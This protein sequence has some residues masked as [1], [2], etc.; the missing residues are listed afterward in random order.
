MKPKTFYY[1]LSI[2]G[3][4][5]TVVL[6]LNLGISVDKLILTLIMY[7]LFSGLFLILTLA[8]L[9]IKLPFVTD[10]IDEP[11]DP[12]YRISNEFTFSDWRLVK[13]EVGY[14]HYNDAI[15][16]LFPPLILLKYKTMVDLEE[17]FEFE[18]KPLNF[19]GSLKDEYEKM[20]QIKYKCDI[21]YNELK[22]RRDEAVSIINQEYE[23]NF[24][25]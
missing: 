16:F 17:S 6:I 20:Y 1:S 25:K 4:L 5:S 22:Q 18:H 8:G 7:T 3:G 12:V 24:K 11:K 10:L 9:T 19:K 13:S 2:I 21:E 15:V 14:S 23:E